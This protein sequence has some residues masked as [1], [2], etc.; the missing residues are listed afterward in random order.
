MTV[1]EGLKHRNRRIV[2]MRRKETSGYEISGIKCH[3]SRSVQFRRG[4]GQQFRGLYVIRQIIRWK[5]L[6]TIFKSILSGMQVPD[7]NTEEKA[8]VV[9]AL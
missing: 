6:G 5:M 3:K 8:M 1:W 7:I 9:A 4:N 2:S